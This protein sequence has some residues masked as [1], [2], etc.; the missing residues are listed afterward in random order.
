[1]A[2]GSSRCR[3]A[4]RASWARSFQCSGSFISNGN[5]GSPAKRYTNHY[6]YQIP[7]EPERD[8]WRI[9]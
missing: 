4:S 9:N 5:S 6:R 8:A 2:S 1:L 7:G 3:A